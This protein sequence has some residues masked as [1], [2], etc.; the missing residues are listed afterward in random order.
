MLHKRD[1]R[2]GTQHWGR[3]YTALGISSYFMADYSNLIISAGMYFTVAVAIFRLW[4]TPP[5]LSIQHVNHR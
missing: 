3:F 4:L 1:S 5:T 2:H